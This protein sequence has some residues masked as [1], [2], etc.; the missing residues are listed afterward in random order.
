MT[1]FW[2]LSMM[3]AMNLAG[4]PNGLARSRGA[5]RVGHGRFANG[6]ERC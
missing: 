1:Q 4:D 3:R 2:L 6:P 5:R